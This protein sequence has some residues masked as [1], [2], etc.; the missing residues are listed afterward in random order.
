MVVVAIFTTELMPPSPPSGTRYSFVLPVQLWICVFATQVAA[1]TLPRGSP[2][3]NRACEYG[4]FD[5]CEAI[6]TFLV[7]LCKI[8]VKSFQQ[9]SHIL[10][11]FFSFKFGLDINP[12]SRVCKQLQFFQSST[13]IICIMSFSSSQRNLTQV[14]GDQVSLIEVVYCSSPSVCCFQCC[15]RDPFTGLLTSLSKISSPPFFL[16]STCSLL[17]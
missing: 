11:L 15:K 17:L 1:T 16:L 13:N 9:P 5:C 14:G 3:L 10:L 6:W 7:K 8:F 2:S 4:K 12:L